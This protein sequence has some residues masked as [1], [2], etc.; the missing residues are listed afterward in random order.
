MNEYGLFCSMRWRAGRVAGETQ[1]WTP[2][3]SGFWFRV[4]G[5]GLH[6]STRRRE[7]AIFSERMGLRKALYLVGLRFEVLLP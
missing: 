3:Y 7:D 2:D 6:V 4:R 1:S 5:Y